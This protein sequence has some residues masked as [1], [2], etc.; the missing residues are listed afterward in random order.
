MTQHP[1]FPGTIP[2][3]F[4]PHDDPTDVMDAVLLPEIPQPGDRV[5]IPGYIC[6]SECPA[7]AGHDWIVVGRV[8]HINQNDEPKALVV[9]RPAVGKP[10]WP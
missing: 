1:V 10:I 9:V 3:E 2:V 6:P 4:V 8:W 7:Q 5:W